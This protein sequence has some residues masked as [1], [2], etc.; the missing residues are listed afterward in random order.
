MASDHHDLKRKTVASIGWTLAKVASD[1]GFS[2]LVFVALARLLNPH[3]MG[4]FALALVVAELGRLLAGAGLGDAVVRVP[5]LDPELADSVFWVNLG[6]ALLL[7]SV[8]VLLAAPI[9]GFFREPALV[10]LERTLACLLPVNAL[11]GIHTARTV[12]DFG[13]KA[14]AARSIASNAL[15]GALAIWAA[16]HGF[17]AWSLVFQRALSETVIMLLAWQ[18]FPW[19]P[20]PRLAFARIR[21]LWSF[22]LNIMLTQVLLFAM[23]RCQDFIIGSSLNASALGIYRLGWRG[24]D[25]LIQLCIAP[26][27]AIALP[28]LSRLADDRAVFAAAVL[29]FNSTIALFGCPAILGFGAIAPQLVPLLFGPQWAAAGVISQV[30]SLLAL[31]HATSSLTGPL[32][33]ARG[34][35]HVTVRLAWLQLGLTVTAVLL[36]VRFGPLVV[37]IVYVVRAY[38]LWPLQIHLLLRET[39]LSLAA[40]FKSVY[41]PATAALIAAGATLVLEPWL[42]RFLHGWGELGAAASLDA[43]V[44]GTLLLFPGRGYVREQYAVLRSLREVAGG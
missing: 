30:L 2:F 3:D 1:Q 6:L 16:L 5:V 18:A 23:I 33:A 39:G 11:G 24:I 28:T 40:L 22:S 20:A 15:A 12:R 9:A 10:P 13:H 34:A 31:P 43:A 42:G 37:A 41:V 25:L 32:F 35:A 29:R 36:A 38:L 17:G 44:F 27:A 21:G 4:V 7:C 8:L 19:V 26:V 14:V